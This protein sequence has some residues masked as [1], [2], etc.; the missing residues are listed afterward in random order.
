MVVL[1]PSVP[2]SASPCLLIHSCLPLV[3]LRLW[4]CLQKLASLAPHEA[5]GQGLG[6]KN[7]NN[8]PPLPPHCQDAQWDPRLAELQGQLLGGGL[9]RNNSDIG[10]S[11]WVG[12]HGPEWV[13]WGLL[14]S[15]AVDHHDPSSCPAK[16][17]TT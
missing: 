5:P 1:S 6:K 15:W 13:L 17:K 14:S 2:L 7:G 10:M 8:Q 12:F 16:T 4:S 11:L 3:W 9:E